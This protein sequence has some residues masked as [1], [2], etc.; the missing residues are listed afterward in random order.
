MEFITR[1]RRVDRQ[2]MRKIQRETA[3]GR[4]VVRVNLTPVESRTFWEDLVEDGREIGTP[5][6]DLHYAAF[7]GRGD[8]DYDGATVKL[9]VE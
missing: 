7:L 4:R 3:R 9:E 6:D 2:I 5:G 1:P 8:Y